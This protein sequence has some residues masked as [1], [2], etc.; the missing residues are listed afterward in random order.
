MSGRYT[1]ALAVYRDTSRQAFQSV[2][3]ALPAVDAQIVAHIE[4]ISYMGG[5]TCAEIEAATGL[6]HQTVSAQVRHMVEAGLLVD[7]GTTRKNENGRACT[8]WALAPTYAGPKPGEKGYLSSLPAVASITGRRVT[9]VVE[10][11][12]PREGRLF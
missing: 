3:D 12:G 4:R 5:A 8:V 9:P 1:A 7:S 6:K 2:L 11:D 10:T